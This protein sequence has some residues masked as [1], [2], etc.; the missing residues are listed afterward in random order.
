[1]KIE[2]LK[3]IKDISLLNIGLCAVENMKKKK[4]ATK[5]DEQIVEI[6]YNELIKRRKREKNNIKQMIYN[7]SSMKQLLRTAREYYDSNPHIATMCYNEIL[8]RRKLDELKCSIDTTSSLEKLENLIKEDNKN[9][10][11]PERKRI[12]YRKNRGSNI[13]SNTK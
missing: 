3:Q 11:K 6:C 2:N 10:I 12:L 7:K 1:M 8:W 5:K 13:N 9:E 4:L